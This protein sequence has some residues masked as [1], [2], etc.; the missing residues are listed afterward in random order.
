VEQDSFLDI[1]ANLVGI[2]II[3]VVIFGAQIGESLSHQPSEELQ[4]LQE[5]LAAQEADWT[6]DR[7]ILDQREA[8]H[9]DWQTVLDQQ[10]ILIQQR[11]LERHLAL[12][13]LAAVNQ[14]VAA[15]QEALTAEQREIRQLHSREIEQAAEIERLTASLDSVRLASVQ[16]VEPVRQ[17]II[18]HYP[19]PIAKTVFGREVHFQLREDRIVYV[20]FDELVQ[21]LKATW[22]THAEHLPVGQTTTETLGPIADFRLQY[23]LNS[24]EKR[25]PTANGSVSSRVVSLSR[26]WLLPVRPDLGESLAAIEDSNSQFQVT[27]AKFSPAETTVSVWVYPESYESFLTLRKTLIQRGYRVAVWPLTSDQRISGSPEGLRS[28]A[29]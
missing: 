13:H 11:R 21:R 20:P 3:L 22:E 25:L 17:E 15:E 18:E 14:M 19:T 16:T 29:Q 2:L 7:Q 10:A 24:Q 8:E 1:I 28:T 4:A 5:Q 27:L 23:E 9:R 6:R 12:Q 26:F